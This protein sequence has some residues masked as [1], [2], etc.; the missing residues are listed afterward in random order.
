MRILHIANVRWFNATAWYAMELARLQQAAGNQ[1]RVVVLPG[2]LA[3]KAGEKRG[4]SLVRLD[5]NTRTPWGT[6][7][8]AREIAD[9]AARFRPQVVNC[10]RGEHFWMWAALRRLRRD[11]ALIRTRGD[12][13][14]P[15]KGAINRW[16]H[17]QADAVISTNSATTQRFRAMGLPSERIYS[18]LGGVDTSVF[19]P[20][21]AA[22]AQVR[23]KLGY[24][25]AH[26]VLG[27]LGRL[28]TVKGQ[29]EIISCLKT[30]FARGHNHLRLMC[31]GF[32]SAI[33]EAAVHAW[34]RAADLERVVTITGHVESVADY[35]NAA[36]LAVVPSLWSEAIARAALEWMACG[37][38]TLASTVGVLPDLFPQEALIPPGDEAAWVQRIEQA[39]DAHFR[40]R[41]RERQ[42]LRLPGL[43][44]AAFLK[45]TMDV[46]AQALTRVEHP[47]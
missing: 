14:P 11:F 33:S 26:L 30:L 41:L 16:L 45:A 9:L 44:S 46:Y 20:N 19:F 18:I 17:L 8:L 4:L 13:R 38:P 25:E 31:I 22:R 32:S 43:T 24:T 34:I 3:E 42:D 37:V 1:V 39:M 7:R 40:T 6:A 35:L 27:L 29:R 36:D 28:D 23:A 47:A 12:Q 5:H 2:T 21:P 15:R 10:H